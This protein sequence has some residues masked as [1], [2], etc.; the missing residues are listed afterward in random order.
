MQKPLIGIPSLY[1]LAFPAREYKS[2]V[3][4][5]EAKKEFFYTSRFQNI[6]DQWVELEIPKMIS[7]EDLKLISSKTT[8]IG[9]C[10]KR[11]KDQLPENAKFGNSKFDTI[12]GIT[13][14]LISQRKFVNQEFEDIFQVEPLYIQ[15]TA[16]EGYV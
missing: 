11:Y 13:L 16:A 2:V 6:D 10:A 12:S 8:L 1:A 5:I 7:L 3:P 4:I 15:K 9:N 14:A